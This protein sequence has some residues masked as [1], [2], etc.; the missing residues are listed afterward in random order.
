M[1]TFDLKPCPF[2]GEAPTIRNGKW[3]NKILRLSAAKARSASSCPLRP[4]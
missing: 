1:K 2:C 3:G 4:C